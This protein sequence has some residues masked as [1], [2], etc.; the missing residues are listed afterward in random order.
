[1][2]IIEALFHLFLF[3]CVTIMGKVAEVS[4]DSFFLQKGSL[5]NSTEQTFNIFVDPKLYTKHFAE[6]FWRYTDE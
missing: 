5:L 6:H 1:M 4:Y 3:T 2:S